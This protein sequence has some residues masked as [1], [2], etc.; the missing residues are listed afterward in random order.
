M[1]VVV[2]YS[3]LPRSNGRGWSKNQRGG[4]GQG[5]G[6]PLKSL[7]TMTS[8][9]RLTAAALR[10]TLTRP[11]RLSSHHHHLLRAWMRREPTGC[12]AP[13]PCHLL[14]CRRMPS[15]R[16]RACS[17]RRLLGRSLPHAEAVSTARVGHRG[18][19]RLNGRGSHGT[20]PVPRVAATS[21][22]W[23]MSEAGL[24]ESSTPESICGC[25]SCVAFPPCEPVCG[26]CL[27]YT[28][29]HRWL[30]VFGFGT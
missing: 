30:D 23:S 29:V 28:T 9:E 20:N 11:L 26:P 27:V 18:S 14:E 1:V 19:W 25:G 24:C 3:L 21:V 5:E 10:W 4:R 22:P 6:R 15:C 13:S 17:T 2:C 12:P 8:T 7:P 16:Q